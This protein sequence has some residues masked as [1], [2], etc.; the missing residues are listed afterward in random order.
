[1]AGKTTTTHGRAGALRLIVVVV[2][3]GG[4]TGKEILADALMLH[5]PIYTRSGWIKIV[6]KIESISQFRRP[7][8]STSDVQIYNLILD[9][10]YISLV[11]K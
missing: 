2:V 7:V 6:V 11:Y 8:K 1:M 5:V 4:G 9:P 10:K 3:V